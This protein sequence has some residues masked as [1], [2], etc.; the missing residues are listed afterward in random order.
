LTITVTR[1]GSTTG[2]VTINYA[3]SNGTAVAGKDYTAKSGTLT[4]GPGVKSQTFMVPVTNNT[5]ADGNRTVHLTLSAPS[6]GAVIGTRGTALATIVDDDV[7]GL[8]QLSATGYTVK[9]DVGSATITVTRSGGAASAV[10]VDYATIDGTA[11]AGT[12]Y[13]AT[14]GTLTFGASEI[15]KTFSVPISN[16]TNSA[17]GTRSLTV[18][19]S[20]PGGGAKLG[21]KSATLT[22]LDGQVGLRFS[23]ADY[24]VKENAKVAIIIVTRTGPLTGAVSVKYATSDGSAVA[25]TD[26]TAKSGTL[27]F[28]KGVVTQSF[29]VPIINNTIVDPTADR[30]VN[31]TLSDPGGGAL[32]GTQPSA[33]LHIVNDDVAGKVQFSAA[34]YSVKETAGSATITVIRKGGA[35]SAVTVHYATSDGTA[36]ASTDYTATSGTLTFGVGVMSR[37]FTVAVIDR[38]TVDGSRTVSLTL[39][40]EGGGAIPGTPATAVLTIQDAPHPDLTMI[41]LSAPTGAAG[42]QLAITSTARNLGSAPAGPFRIDFYLSSDNALDVNTD[43]LV[44][45]RK[46]TGL[47]ALTSALA[48]TIVTLPADMTPGPYYLIAVADAGQQVKEIDETNNTLTTAQPIQIEPDVRGVYNLA[49]SS[50]TLSSCLAAGNNGTFPLS[51]TTNVSSQSGANFSGSAALLFSTNMASLRINVAFSAQIQAGSNNFSGVHSFG[52]TIPPSAAVVARGTGTL[53]NGTFTES[54]GQDSF[55]V[56]LSGQTQSGIERCHVEAS[57]QGSK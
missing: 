23:A 7:A 45:S 27:T 30:T 52:V 40:D 43:R 19:L 32:L 9:E 29:V 11:K 16:N 36:K 53:N 54:A 44:G 57:L 15:T 26:Y 50:I 28:A 47:A 35:A 12:D 37:T 24:S 21:R 3:T 56:T 22:I 39:S 51:G 8:V 6:G 31:L 1:T 4:F 18:T 46:V 10:T 42:G 33:T 55:N 49:G 20:N 5:I 13:T 38:P 2:T 17:E 41:Q 25:G 34:L 48:T 14:S